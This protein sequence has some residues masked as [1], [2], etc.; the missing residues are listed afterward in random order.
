MKINFT[1]HST[2]EREVE[3]TQQ[4]MMLVFELMKQHFLTHIEFGTFD[5]SRYYSTD[6]EAGTVKLCCNHQVDFAY[7]KDRLAFFQAIMNNMEN[8]YSD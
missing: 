2:T 8:P 6:E 4:E 5:A 3:L 1:G 7:T